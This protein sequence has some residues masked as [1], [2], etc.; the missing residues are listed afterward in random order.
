MGHS[1]YT[2]FIGNWVHH[3]N[4][5]KAALQKIHVTSKNVI[6]Y[7]LW[8]GEARRWKKTR[9]RNIW[10]TVWGVYCREKMKAWEVGFPW[11]QVPWKKETFPLST[12][13]IVF[14][15]KKQ[16]FSSV[17][18]LFIY[19]FY[20]LFCSWL[21]LLTRST[22]L[23]QPCFADSVI[24]SLSQISLNSFFFLLFY[25]LTKCQYNAVKVIKVPCPE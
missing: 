24:S 5:S 6:S 18:N 25:L 23:C 14:C 7:E 10:V 21:L 16:N 20:V 17:E 12:A 15:N 3:K 9:Y 2:L 4:E 11:W 1:G 8:R 22:V 19:S 13:L